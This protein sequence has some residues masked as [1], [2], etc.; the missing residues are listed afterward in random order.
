MGLMEEIEALARAKGISLPA[1]CVAGAVV[2]VERFPPA[3]K[4]SLQLDFERGGR[5]ELELFIGYAVRAG[6]TLGIPVPLH[7]ELYAALRQRSPT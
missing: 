4:S 3:T 6:R 2:K 5:N 1:D 7:E